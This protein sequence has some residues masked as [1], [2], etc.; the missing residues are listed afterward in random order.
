MCI[1]Y[2]ILNLLGQQL[3]LISYASDVIEPCEQ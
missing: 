3:V 2:T 1:Y